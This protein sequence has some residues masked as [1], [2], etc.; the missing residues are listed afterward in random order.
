MYSGEAIPLFAVPLGPDLT[1]GDTVEIGAG[2]FS[3]D[4]VVSS[5]SD[6]VAITTDFDT[7]THRFVRVGPD[8][9]PAD[10]PVD[11]APQAD[12]FGLRVAWAGDRWA[13]VWFSPFEGMVPGDVF[14]H[15]YG[16]L[17]DP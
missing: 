9:Q 13:V 8:G 3:P 15:T 1:P 2:F 10:G 14:L 7:D 4:G 11:L 16:C 12:R 5:G 17:P 6:V